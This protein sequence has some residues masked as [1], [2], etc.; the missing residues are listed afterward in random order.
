M[1]RDFEHIDFTLLFNSSL[2]EKQDICNTAARAIADNM[3][4]AADFSNVLDQS[5]SVTATEL[6]ELVDEFYTELGV[7]S[8][9]MG[10]NPMVGKHPTV[11]RLEFD[12]YLQLM[13]SYFVAGF[14]KE[15]AESLGVD[16]LGTEESKPAEP[17][18]V[19][20]VED[21][22]DFTNVRLRDTIR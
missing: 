15:L 22:A 1:V 9:C 8:F 14:T 13:S 3:Q 11:E 12:S 18:P 4:F 7:P 21:T 19:G 6:N 2:K 17:E 16:V 20:Y 5:Q 10:K